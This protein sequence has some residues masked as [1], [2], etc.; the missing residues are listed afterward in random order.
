MEVIYTVKTGTENNVDVYIVSGADDP[1]TACTNVNE[2][3]ANEYECSGN[4]YYFIK[5][6]SNVNWQDFVADEYYDSD[7]TMEKPVEG[8][9]M[10]EKGFIFKRYVLD[11]EAYN[12]AKIKY[13]AKLG[14]DKIREEL[15]KLDLG[16]AVKDEYT[17]YVYNSATTQKL[18]TGVVLDNIISN[19]LHGAPGIVF[20]KSAIDVN[21]KITMD[22]LSSIASSKSV[23]AAMDYVRNNVVNSYTVSNN[24]FYSWYDSNK[25]LE[26]TVKEYD[27]SK[28]NF[29]F[30]DRNVMYAFSSG[31]LYYNGI[32]ESEISAG[33]LI[34]S[35]VTSYAVADG[36]LYYYKTSGSALPSLYRFS[37]DKG[38]QTLC[39]N[40]YSYLPIDENYVIILSG[41]SDNSKD[42]MSVG[43]FSAD[44]YKVIDTDVSLTGFTHNGYAFGY[45]KNN[46]KE[47]YVASL[48]D[49]TSKISDGV[50]DIYYIGE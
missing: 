32:T 12:N 50:T 1:V 13:E 4:L 36:Y 49:G 27:A 6:K 25:V 21:S 42:S 34:D 41:N 18:A 39:E 15:N 43:V 33:K 22:K 29:V 30:G 10:I 20:R 46:N 31:K 16:L 38:T 5:N 8:D 7:A 40:V 11:S 9:F 23:L 35:N 44:G 19:S 48:E 3:Y 2:V 26:Y 28:T 17:C 45:L 47:L 14:R 37:P 24:C